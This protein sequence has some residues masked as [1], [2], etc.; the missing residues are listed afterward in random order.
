[1]PRPLSVDHTRV[2][3]NEV[4]SEVVGA[5][6]VNANYIS[7]EVPGS[8]NRYIATQVCPRGCGLSMMYNYDVI[9]MSPGDSGRLL[10]DD[11]AAKQ[12]NHRHD[13]Q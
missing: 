1:M 5:D 8:E 10:E 11:L 7:G 4:E 3:L 6:Y 2:T 13:N 9:G 12:P